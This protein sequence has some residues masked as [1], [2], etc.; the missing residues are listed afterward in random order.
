LKEEKDHTKA[1]PLASFGHPS[2]RQS[3][4]RENNKEENGVED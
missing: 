3:Q 1:D 2:L 4:K